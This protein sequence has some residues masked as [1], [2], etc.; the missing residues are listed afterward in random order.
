MRLHRTFYG[1]PAGEMAQPLQGTK[2][3]ITGLGG[4]SACRRETPH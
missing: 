2:L 3:T 4:T 1:Y